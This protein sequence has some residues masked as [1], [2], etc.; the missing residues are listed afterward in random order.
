MRNALVILDPPRP[1]TAQ[2][3]IDTAMASHAAE[4]GVVMVRVY[5]WQPPAVS[6][7]R[8]Q[9]AEEVRADVA[10]AL[11]IDIVRR[12]SGGR[13]IVHSPRDITYSIAAP[14]GDPIH[15]APVEE[16]AARAASIVAGALRR[17]GVP[18]KTR[19]PTPYK[20][21]GPICLLASGSGDILVGN[22]K[23]SG[24]AVLRGRRATLVHGVVLV[25]HSPST[26][27][28]LIRAS[29]AEARL[30]QERVAGLESLGLPVRPGEM[31]RSLLS[32]L[33]ARGYHAEPGGLPWSVSE[34]AQASG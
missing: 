9:P 12:P 1:G 27:L 28:A 18:A 25:E 16:A 23:I 30:F 8:S 4:T 2:M 21:M 13:A 11:G 32:E 24:A 10:A 22:L 3:A 26:W 33:E 17:L 7:G 34:R 31:A 14:R 20:P 5:T 6:L 15:E 19:G 29:K